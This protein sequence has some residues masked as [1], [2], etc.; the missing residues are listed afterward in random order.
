MET[1]NNVNNAV[2][3]IAGQSVVLSQN[4]EIDNDMSFCK[5]LVSS[6]K[7]LRSKKNRLARV[8]IQK[9]LIRNWV[10]RKYRVNIYN[11]FHHY[12]GGVSSSSTSSEVEFFCD[13]T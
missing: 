1:L 2:K 4:D 6:L 9:F 10:W 8:K 5:S 3:T 12:I 11:D 7:A 13:T